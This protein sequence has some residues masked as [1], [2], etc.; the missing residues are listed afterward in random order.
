[1]DEKQNNKDASTKR[2][3]FLS[4]WG[5][6]HSMHAYLFK[7]APWSYLMYIAWFVGIALLLDFIF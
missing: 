6:R 5:A 4:K 1:M 7:H 2:G 3:G